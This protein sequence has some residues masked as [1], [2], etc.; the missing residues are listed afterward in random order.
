MRRPSPRREVRKGLA[1][2]TRARAPR[3]G[4]RGRVQRWAA[5]ARESARAARSA[6]SVTM[7]QSTPGES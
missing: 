6:R 4:A 1:A 7:L 5:L 2:P 3:L